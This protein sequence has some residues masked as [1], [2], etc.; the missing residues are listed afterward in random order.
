MAGIGWGGRMGIG[1]SS[2]LVAIL[3][4]PLPPFFLFLEKI[5]NIFWDLPLFAV[6]LHRVGGNLGEASHRV[7]SQLTI[8]QS[9]TKGFIPL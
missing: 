6:R 9:P 3:H 5:R 1:A 4:P 7:L 2:S 8:R